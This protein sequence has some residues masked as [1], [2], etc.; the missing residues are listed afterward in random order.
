MKFVKYVKEFKPKID[1]AIKEIYERKIKTIKNSF[2]N[3]YYSELSDYFL[4]GG[5]R[6]RPLLCI[7]TYNAFNT[8]KDNKIIIPSVGTEFLH[9]ASLI[10]DDLID[11]DEF[12]RG[13][14]AFHYRFKQYHRKYNLKKMIAED[15]GD[16]VGI[17]GGDTA[18]I[19]GLEAYLF[20]EFE[21]DVNLTAIRY[22]EQAFVGICDGVLIELDMVN[23][24][25]LTIEDYIEMISLKTGALIEKSML[26]GANYARVD[27]QYKPLISTYGINLGIIFQ[28]IDDILGTFGDE[29]VTGKPTDGDIREGKKTC[30][31][32]EAYSKLDEEKKNKLTDLIEKSEMTEN[33]VQAVKELFLE[34][35]APNS[36]RTLAQS[37]YEEA[38]NSLLK[39]EQVINQSEME[40]FLDLLNFVVNRKF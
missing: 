28:I 11:K 15:F 29:K 20:N 1:N 32:I 38:K 35:D 17:I 19:M 24:K 12:R 31:L 36:C 39:L 13:N 10:H 16:N 23:K 8:I 7:A 18:F 37:Y 5:K 33:D 9:N 26:I 4:A 30:L 2:L 34:A 14:P 3:D 22:Y 25:E 27:E 6:I 21:Q 40:F